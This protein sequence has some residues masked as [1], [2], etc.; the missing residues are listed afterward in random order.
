[1]RSI[2]KLNQLLA[3]SAF[4]ALLSGCNVGPKYTRPTYPAPPAFRGADDAA[5]TSDAKA[6]LGDQQWS[7]VFQEP[8]L[9]ELIR[10]ALVNNYDTRIAVQHILEQSAQV[11]IT[12]SQQFPTFTVGGLGAGAD[13]PSLGSSNSISS[14]IVEG[15]L[16]VSAAWNPDFWGLYR[17]Q[18]D[19]QRDQL[20]AQTW[21]QRAVRLTLVQQVTTAYLQL[22]SLDSSTRDHEADAKG[23]AGFAE[24]DADARNRWRCSA[25]GR[26]P[27]GAAA[28]H[29]DVADS[30]TGAADPAAGER[31]SSA[32]GR[33]PRTAAAA[34]SAYHRA[35]SA[36]RAGRCAF[37]A[38]GAPA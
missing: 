6:S 28:L 23:A 24:A 5:V 8:E 13:I 33:E 31:D 17:K 35:A 16:S 29:R 10:K 7:A 1:M 18:T 25:F 30:A 11:K 20:L 36:R 27:S 19:V 38:A 32:A 14:P 9:Q 15:A 12:R 21:A 22:R 37:A 3:T 34:G 26:A 2:M 4:A